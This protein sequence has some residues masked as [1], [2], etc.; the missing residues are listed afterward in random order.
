MKELQRYSPPWAEVLCFAPNRGLCYDDSWV[1]GE[2][3]DGSDNGI[4]LPDDEWG[5]GGNG[6][7]ELPDDKL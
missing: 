6:G 4:E 1:R 7:I 3:Y 5:G 2:S